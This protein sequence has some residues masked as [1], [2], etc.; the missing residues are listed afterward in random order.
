M[1]AFLGKVLGFLPDL[2]RFYEGLFIYFGS[3]VGG[4]ERRVVLECLL[5]V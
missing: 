1:F 3:E 2:S 5:M 4:D